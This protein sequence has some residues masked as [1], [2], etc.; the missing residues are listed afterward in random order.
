M[1]GSRRTNQGKKKYSSNT[2]GRDRDQIPKSLPPVN[3]QLSV[4]MRLR[5]VTTAQFT[6]T[7]TVTPY[8]LLD[9]WFIAG[10]ATTAYQLFD[11]VKVK[12]VT[13]RAMGIATGG[14]GGITVA[15][16]AS[17]GIEYIGLSAGVFGSGK[18]AENSGIGYDQPAMVSLCPDPKS[19]VAQFQ[20]QSG[21]AMFVIRAV[22]QYGSAIEG[23]IIDVD[24]VYKNSADVSP[25]AVA[26]ARTALTSG[27]LYF[28]G[29]DGNPLATTAARS[30]FQ[31]RA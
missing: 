6:G 9:A 30:T 22:D 28:G 27:N 5:F 18:Q 24:V 20:P 8:N 31:R 25:S 26:V 2:K 21:N 17:V 14:G 7:V 10:T 3:D 13:V 1:K 16:F 15:P 11:F 23:V 4:G 29:L 12:R 19:Q